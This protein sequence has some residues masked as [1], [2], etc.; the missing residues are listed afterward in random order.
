VTTP[1]IE[2]SGGWR[3][4]SGGWQDGSELDGGGTTGA[5][6]GAGGAELDERRREAEGGTRKMT[7]GVVR[8]S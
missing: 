8:S 5:T 3:G 7:I 4:T 1:T 2:A 6:D